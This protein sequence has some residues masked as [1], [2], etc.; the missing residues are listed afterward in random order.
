[1]SDQEGPGADSA[2]AAS[3]ASLGSG[4]SSASNRFLNPKST[5]KQLPPP[6]PRAQHRSGYLSPSHQVSDPSSSQIGGPSV[7]EKSAAVEKMISA[8]AFLQVISVLAF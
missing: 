8:L 4:T 1:M 7:K 2:S 6:P 5:S 3:V